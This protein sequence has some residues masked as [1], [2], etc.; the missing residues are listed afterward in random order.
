MLNLENLFLFFF[1]IYIDFIV[2]TFYVE[3]EVDISTSESSL[4]VNG[5]GFI[6]T[7]WQP[8]WLYEGWLLQTGMEG[9]NIYSKE[10]VFAHHNYTFQTSGSAD[11]ITFAAM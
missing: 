7:L 5:N 3:R 9:A 1:F 11:A 10:H 2:N 6:S 8:L 4:I